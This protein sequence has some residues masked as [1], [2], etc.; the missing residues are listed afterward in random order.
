MKTSGLIIWLTLISAANLFGQTEF[1]HVNFKKADSIA[2]LYPKHSLMDLALLAGKLTDALSTDVEKFRAIY[3]WTCDNVA[4]DYS[5]YVQSQQKNK[6]KTPGELAVWN[7]KFRHQVF[8]ILIQ[9]HRSVCTGYAY[10]LKTLSAY[11][12]LK[13]QIIEGYGR[14]AKANI[15]GDGIPNHS[16]NAI[17]LD[18]HWYL[19]DA[20]WSSGAINLDLKKFVQ[21]FDASYFLA[22]PVL[23]VRNHYPLDTAWMLLDRKPS[24]HEFLNRPLIYSAIY[25]YKVDTLFPDTFQVITEKGKKV[26]L[27]FAANTDKPIEKAELSIVKG[28]NI[29]LIPEILRRGDNGLFE[30]GHTFT[31][32]GIHIVHL[33]LNSR[34]VCTYTVQVK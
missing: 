10:L 33:L 6:L 28:S 20:T 27:Q 9:K 15:G 22:D 12:G 25:D 11:A 32:K 13:C 26:S 18:N 19:C 17:Y 21:H 16:W 4:N 1:G 31:Q 14:T 7:R 29:T 34:Y 2:A 24:L 30:V 5:L 3:K 23:F 8:R